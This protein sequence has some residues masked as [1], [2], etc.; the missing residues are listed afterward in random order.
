[1]HAITART[2][3]HPKMAWG[4]TRLNGRDIVLEVG[5]K[6]GFVLGILGFC[7]ILYLPDTSG[8][9]VSSLKVVLRHSRDDVVAMVGTS[10][11]EVDCENLSSALQKAESIHVDVPKDFEETGRKGIQLS[12]GGTTLYDVTESQM[13]GLKRTLAL[14]LLMAIFWITETLP[15][16]VVALFPMIFL[17]LLGVTHFSRASMPGYFVAFSPYMHYLIVLFIGGFTIA[18]AMKKWQLHERIA[19]QFVRL[20]GFSPKRIILSFMVATA[21]VSMFV[22]N[23]A[24]AAMMMPIGLAIILSTGESPMKSNFGRALMLGIAYA[25]SI[26]GIGTLIGTPPNLVLAAFADTLL[27]KT[28]TFRDWLLIGLPL[29]A[30][31]LPVT[32]L[33]LLRLNPIGEVKMPASR[34]VVEDRLKKLGR[35]RGGERNTLCIFVLVAVL[36]VFRE[37]WTSALHLPWVNDSVIGMIGLVLFY[38]VPV[39]I[40]KWEFTMDWKT[41]LQIPW[42]TLLLFG[43]GLTLGRA[44]AETGAAEYLAM[45]LVGLRMLPTVLLLF[46]VVLLVDFLTEITSNTATTNMMMVVL[47]CLGSA[48]G[49][50]PLLLMVGGAV[51]ASMAFMLPVA[52]PPNAI[53]YGTGYVE[54]KDMVKNGFVL[55]WIAAAVWTLLLYFVLSRISGA[56][57]L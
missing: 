37:W 12:E 21:A 24:T 2:Q 4:L 53:V 36:W 22:S 55:D 7:V 16:P 3:I 54:M 26:G 46:T 23:T 11:L 40:R 34:R 15:I 41:N 49:E 56:L 25:A 32:W 5:K 48:I 29:V 43:G 8:M 6:F 35:L 28:I 45:H 20:I 50:C 57:H 27:G 39:N 47:C 51:A 30:I 14:A 13:D 1:M 42:G 44:L 31:L 18:E 9:W 33:V 17:P 52:T 10:D 38:T 19:L